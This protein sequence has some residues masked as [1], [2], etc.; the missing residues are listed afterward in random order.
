MRRVLLAATTAAAAAPH[1]A[2]APRG[3]LRLHGGAQRERVLHGARERESIIE[4]NRIL[5]RFCVMLDVLKDLGLPYSLENPASSYMWADG[6][7]QAR[8]R[9]SHDIVVTHCAF[10]AKHRKR[11]K[12]IFNNWS[13]FR[14]LK[15]FWKNF[16]VST[17]AC[18]NPPWSYA[19]FA[20]GCPQKTQGNE[21][22]MFL[23]CICCC[24]DFMNEW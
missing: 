13:T 2:A 11:T 6:A 23:A 12:L 7:V 15:R 16:A 18:L 19:E 9:G 1:R 3:R 17:C 14:L 10:G 5:D 24:F 20:T 4:G 22:I 8:L 21:H